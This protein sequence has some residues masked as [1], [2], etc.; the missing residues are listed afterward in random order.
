M[1]CRFV[2][3]LGRA[4][5]KVANNPSNIRVLHTASFCALSFGCIRLTPVEQTTLGNH[6]QTPDLP[7]VR[8][9][10]T[11]SLPEWSLSARKNDTIH[12][13]V[14]AQAPNDEYEGSFVSNQL[15]V[16][17]RHLERLQEGAVEGIRHRWKTE[18]GRVVLS[19]IAANLVVLALWK[20]LPTSFMVRHFASS[21]EAMRRGRVWTALTCNFSQ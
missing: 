8:T 7:D 15:K 6:S 13:T 16:A 5:A 12:C 3:S 18:E 4:A 10:C 1:S 9:K 19:I 2:W 21:L 20:V 14:V 17:R 11:E